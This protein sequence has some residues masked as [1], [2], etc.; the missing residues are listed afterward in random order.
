MLLQRCYPGLDL[1]AL[2]VFFGFVCTVAGLVL[3]LVI[4]NFAD[5]LELYAGMPAREIL[6]DVLDDLTA[7]I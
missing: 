3:S 4:G 7:N 1:V 5:G 2:W 6:K